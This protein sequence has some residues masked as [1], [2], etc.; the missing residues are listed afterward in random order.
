MG[1]S[2]IICRMMFDRSLGLFDVIYLGGIVKAI[3]GM[4]LLIAPAVAYSMCYT[5]WDSSNKVVYESSHTPVALDGASGSNLVQE[6]F[7][8]GHLIIEPRDCYAESYAPIPVGMSG[9]G[10]GSGHSSSG[11]MGISG[12]Y[13]SSSTPSGAGYSSGSLSSSSN[14]YQPTYTGPRGGVYHMSSTGN[15]VYHKR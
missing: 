4:V 14:G 9:H 10:M 6:R 15:K 2:E 12:G 11:G 5:V 13:V 3:M 1:K 7:P 8:G